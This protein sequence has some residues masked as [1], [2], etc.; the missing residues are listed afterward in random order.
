L[1]GSVE[2]G[3]I[4]KRDLLGAALGQEL[5]LRERTIQRTDVEFGCIRFESN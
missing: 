5:Q 4:V 1:P 2:Q 3:I